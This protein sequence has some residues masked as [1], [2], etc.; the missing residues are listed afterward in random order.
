MD[1]V[2][3][4]AVIGSSVSGLYQGFKGGESNTRDSTWR[5]GRREKTNRV[6][7]EIRFING[8]SITSGQSR[9]G[10][11]QAQELTQGVQVGFCGVARIPGVHR[12]E[13]GAN[14]G[15]ESGI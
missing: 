9:V 4:K 13:V 10:G 12:G 8:G 15:K 2:D 11:A 6:C 5:T 1:K 7:A 14:R 3:E